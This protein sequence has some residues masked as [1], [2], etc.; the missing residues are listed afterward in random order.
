MPL[1]HVLTVLQGTCVLP[2]SHE[3]YLPGNASRLAQVG[4]RLPCA[5]AAA[6]HSCADSGSKLPKT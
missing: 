6:L 4:C 3:A 5:A 2:V 1:L